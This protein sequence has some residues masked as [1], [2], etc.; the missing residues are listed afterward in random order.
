MAGQQVE[1]GTL[2]RTPLQVPQRVVKLLSICTRI[3]ADIQR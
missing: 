3:S 1:R 2:R